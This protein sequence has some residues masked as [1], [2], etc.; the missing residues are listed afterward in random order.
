MHVEDIICLC[1]VGTSEGTTGNSTQTTDTTSAAQQGTSGHP[2]TAA[3][4]SSTPSSASQGSSETDKKQSTT[5]LS[6]KHVK[7]VYIGQILKWK[8]QPEFKIYKYVFDDDSH[9]LE[10][11]ALLQIANEKVQ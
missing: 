8:W 1:S 10:V 6:S 4:A 7:D 11:V 9:L 2:P 5:I 3:A